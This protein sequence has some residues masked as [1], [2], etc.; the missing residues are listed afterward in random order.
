M[1]PLCRDCDKPMQPVE[2][3]LPIWRCACGR[4]IP[5]ATGIVADQVTELVAPDRLDARAAAGR[6]GITIPALRRAAGAGRVVGAQR[7]EQGWTFD[8]D[9]LELRGR[10]GRAAGA[11]AAVRAITSATK[12]AA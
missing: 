6:L 4:E 9:R 8:P 12:R 10:R 5:R 1:N 11:S 3:L 2:A 7:D